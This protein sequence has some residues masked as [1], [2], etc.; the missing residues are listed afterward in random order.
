MTVLYLICSGDYSFISSPVWRVVFIIA[1]IT[2]GMTVIEYFTGL[3]F[4][5]TFK[6]NLWYYSDRWD[7]IQ[8]IICPLF[9]LIWGAIGAAY[10]F[11]LHS[12]I[13]AAAEWIAENPEFSIF[14]GISA[15]L[16]STS[17]TRSTS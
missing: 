3:F 11:L 5:K 9:S 7:N 12:S 1:A 2:V 13:S 15:C 4:V 10:Y 8:G 16:S 6:V 17:Y 14:V